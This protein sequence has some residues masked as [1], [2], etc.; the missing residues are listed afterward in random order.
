LGVGGGAGR[1]Q[2]NIDY[3]LGRACELGGPCAQWASG[4]SQRR[5]IESI[6]SL[7]GLVSLTDKHSFRAVNHACAR[8]VAADLWRL[9]DVRALLQT[10]ELQTQFSFSQEHPLIRNLN[11]YGLFIK[12]HTS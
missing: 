12:T 5:G 8:A 7:M 1:L 9:R 2:S 3:W 10:G 4:L 11:E 6:R